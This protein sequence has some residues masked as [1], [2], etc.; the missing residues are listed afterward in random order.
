MPTDAPR[1]SLEHNR[2]PRRTGRSGLVAWIG[3]G[4]IA[5]LFL[6][7]LR[8]RPLPI[9]VDGVNHSL[10]GQ[11]L[12]FFELEPLTGDGQPVSMA[13]LKGKVTLINIWGTWCPPCVEEFP[14]L[15]AIHDK[16]QSR[17][18][19]QYLSV[20]YD[21]I[22]EAELR[23]ATSDFLQRMRVDHPTYHDPGAATLNALYMLGVDR[24]FP[25]TIVLDEEGTIRGVWRGYNRS[26]MVEIERLLGE[27]LE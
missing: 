22:P 5:L 20:S 15:A 1:D 23:E 25:T 18:D 26:A 10:V 2:L 24:A 14:Y 27:L 4:L 3:L 17:A 16:F 13:D 7:Y 21:E 12:V 19:F 11:R 6:T 8:W 9:G